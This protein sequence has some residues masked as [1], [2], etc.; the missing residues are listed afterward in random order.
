M[1]KCKSSMAYSSTM[2][3]AISLGPMKQGQQP[4][5]TNDKQIWA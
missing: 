1:G 4:L 3:K 2:N 5:R